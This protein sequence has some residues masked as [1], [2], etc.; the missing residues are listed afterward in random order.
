MTDEEEVQRLPTW[1][2]QET[3]YMVRR[4]SQQ[5]KYVLNVAAILSRWL[6]E[7]RWRRFFAWIHLNNNRGEKTFRSYFST[8]YFQEIWSFRENAVLHEQAQVFFQKIKR[9]DKT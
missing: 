5:K 2:W 7:A 9:M 8:W 4:S 6:I 1:P 3:N